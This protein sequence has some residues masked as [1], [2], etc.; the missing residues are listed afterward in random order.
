MG[1]A[2]RILLTFLRGVTFL[3]DMAKGSGGSGEIETLGS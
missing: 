1:I 3:F 2:L